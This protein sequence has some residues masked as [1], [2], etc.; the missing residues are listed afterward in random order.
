MTSAYYDEY[1]TF[2]NAVPINCIQPKSRSTY[3]LH[4]PPPTCQDCCQALVWSLA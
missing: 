2:P 1:I 3:C 4:K